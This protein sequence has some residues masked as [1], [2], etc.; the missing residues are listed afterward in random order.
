LLQRLDHLELLIDPLRGNA[1]NS[2]LQGI[3][4]LQVALISSKNAR[5]FAAVY[6]GDI[7][8]KTIISSAGP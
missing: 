6:G 5:R 3:L 4:N 1:K 8:T 2:A 7:C